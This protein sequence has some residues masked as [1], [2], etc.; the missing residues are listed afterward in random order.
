MLACYYEQKVNEMPLAK[1]F[2]KLVIKPLGPNA[3]H[4][5]N[6]FFAHPK[7]G[8]IHVTAESQVP[9]KYFIRHRSADGT[10]LQTR[11][12]ATLD[13]VHHVLEKEFGV[14]LTKAEII[15]PKKKK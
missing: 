14:D 7:G 6:R 10:L 4:V 13:H 1:S 9:N 11:G 15:R 2:K 12:V 3:P 5:V 8:S